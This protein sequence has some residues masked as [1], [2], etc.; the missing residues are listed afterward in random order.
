MRQRLKHMV[1]PSMK[2]MMMPNLF[3]PGFERCTPA[4]TIENNTADVQKLQ[5]QENMLKRA[6]ER[7]R[8]A[9][10]WHFCAVVCAELEGAVEPV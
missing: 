1:M 2:T 3:A 4:K 7:E 9:A 6:F 10:G 8:P 5:P